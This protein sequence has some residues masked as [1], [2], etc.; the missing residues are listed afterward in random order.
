MGESRKVRLAM[1]MLQRGDRS[2]VCGVALKGRR[3]GC[4][5]GHLET[6]LVVTRPG[7]KLALFGH[8]AAPF[9]STT[10]LPAR[11]MLLPPRKSRQGTDPG[12]L[13]DTLLKR[14]VPSMMS[15]NED[16]VFGTDKANVRNL[17]G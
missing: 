1:S 6:L 2:E 4:L 5:L 13:D 17:C 10:P 12:H 11:T 8:H 16:A 15:A 3:T 14:R 9:P 7:R